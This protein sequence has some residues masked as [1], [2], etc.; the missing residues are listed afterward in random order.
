MQTLTPDEARGELSDMR[1]DFDEMVR[2]SAFAQEQLGRAYQIAVSR[3]LGQVAGFK[4]TWDYFSRYVKGLTREALERYRYVTLRWNSAVTQKYDLESLHY[5]GEYLRTHAAS[6]PYT[7]DPGPLLIRVPQANG[8]E[9]RKTF[10]ECGLDEI[11]RASRPKRVATPRGRPSLTDSMR[12]L[13]VADGIIRNFTGVAH[14]SIDMRTQLDGKSF[15]TVQGIPMTELGRLITALQDGVGAQP[16][17]LRA[18][19]KA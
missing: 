13:F 6:G 4:D 5:L 10:T 12:L 2:R 8:T 16:V 19:N 17:S 3:R 11:R 7:Q 14:V 15:L 18:E 1:E 9:V